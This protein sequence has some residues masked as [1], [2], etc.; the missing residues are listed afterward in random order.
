MDSK[1]H[2]HEIKIKRQFGNRSP[3]AGS[4][5]FV[6]NYGD[7]NVDVRRGPFFERRMR[8]AVRRAIRLHDRGSV[9]AGEKVAYHAQLNQWAASEAERVRTW[10][11]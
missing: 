7:T 8:R 3:D 1:P 6:V 10:T 11:S 9:A 5:C 4:G 2:T